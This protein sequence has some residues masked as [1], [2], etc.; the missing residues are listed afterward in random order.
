MDVDVIVSTIVT[1]EVIPI[2]D[3]MIDIIIALG[4]CN[5]VTGATPS[6]LG[7]T[8]HIVNVTI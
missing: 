2:R 6:E 4:T 1:T 5:D 7:T 8:I 3:D